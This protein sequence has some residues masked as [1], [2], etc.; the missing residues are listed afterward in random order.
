M[1][2]IGCCLSGLVSLFL[3][4][5]GGARLDG[6]APYVEGL[7]KFGYSP[8]LAP[9][10]GLSLLVST[11]LYLVPRTT[12]LGAILITGY[13]GG[14]TATQMRVGDPW[15]LFPVA[16]DVMAW[17]GLWCRSPRIRALLPLMR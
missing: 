8:T 9:W 5:D 2:R 12:V 6:F 15:F 7:T 1:C 11:V 16:F 3:L 14:A 10:I 13:L 17:A 4:M